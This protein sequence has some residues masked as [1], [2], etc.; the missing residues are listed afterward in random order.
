VPDAR[1]RVVP[2][3]VP[4][5]HFTVADAADQKEARQSF[6]VDPDVPVVAYVGALAVEKGVDVAVEAVAAVPGLHLLI[7][8]DGPQRSALR[9]LAARC[10][11]D[12]VHLVGVLDDVTTAYAAADIVVLP[13]RG[14]DSMPA[15]LIEA[16]LCGRPAVATAVGAIPDVVEPGVT[17]ALVPVGDPLRLARTLEALLADPDELAALGAAARARGLERFDIDIVA[18]GWQ[19]AL[20]DAVAL[21]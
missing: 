15:A 9:E 8:G 4:S 6:G 7:A 19:A 21:K 17:G 10:A 3:G 14:G 16:G 1:I 11:P 18:R 20:D 12:R 2:N 5:T 13:S